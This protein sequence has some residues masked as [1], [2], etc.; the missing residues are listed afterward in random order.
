MVPHRCRV[1]LSTPSSKPDSNA[2]ISLCSPGRLPQAGPTSASH[3]YLL[4]E[5]DRP[6]HKWDLCRSPST[7][8]LFFNQS[9][10]RFRLARQAPNSSLHLAG[11]K[12]TTA[13]QFPT[14]HCEDFPQLY[15]IPTGK[16]VV[17]TLQEG[18]MTSVIH[19]IEK[20]KKIRTKNCNQ[21]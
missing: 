18:A 3:R 11:D 2:D 13:N 4:M 16:G 10:K 14:K 15:K 6:L 17:V 8:G 19:A 9:F 7:L 5:A 20:K 21:E 1:Q 12:A